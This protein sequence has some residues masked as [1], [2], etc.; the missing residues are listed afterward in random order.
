MSAPRHPD[1]EA[2]LRAERE[3]VFAFGGYALE[4]AG[5]IA[6]INER[7]PVPRFNFVEEVDLARNRM[8][9]FFE[10]VLDH[11][12]QRAIRPTFRL[13]D[14]P[15]PYLVETLERFGFRA[16]AEPHSLLLCRRTSPLPPPPEGYVVRA[17]DPEEVDAVV[18]F[19]AETRE[20]EEL[21][22]S[23]EVLWAHPNPCERVIPV[24]AFEGGAATSAAIVYGYR[25]LWG[26]HAVATQPS[27]RGRGA[28]SAIV[29]VTLSTIIPPSAAPVVISADH[30]RIRRR[31]EALGFHEIARER[32]FELDPAAQL[33]LPPVPP[34]K[35]PL[36]RPPR[37]S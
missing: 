12:Y 7:I 1:L 13:P 37:S 36:W 23:L 34:S 6:V 22:R 24:L 31:L 14:P 15:P 21:R 30:S 17:A 29:A 9:P 26:I 2:A 8:S 20:R 11:Y 28:A 3:L 32:V 35:G 5:G 19:W 25:G 27:A 10:R 33:A 16:R 4:T 18:D